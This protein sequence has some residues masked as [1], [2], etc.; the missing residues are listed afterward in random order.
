M[1]ALD[2][3]AIF[4]IG[5]GI[6]GRATVGVFHGNADPTIA[7]WH[8]CAFDRVQDFEPPIV[9]LEYLTEDRNPDTGLGD[10]VWGEPLAPDHQGKRIASPEAPDAWIIFHPGVVIRKASLEGAVNEY[11]M[12]G[13]G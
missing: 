4:H 8:I 13:L 2:R 12:H 7:V 5:P 10:Q 1:D 11:A 3:R 6:D 9:Q